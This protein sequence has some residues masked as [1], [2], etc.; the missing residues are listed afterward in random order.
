MNRSVALLTGVAGA[1]ALCIGACAAG[2]AGSKLTDDDDDSGQAAAGPGT[3]G[4]DFNPGDGGGDTGDGTICQTAPNLDLD[5]DDWTPSE[6]DCND[7]DANVNPGAIEVMT[8]LSDPNALEI[9]ENCDGEID[10][11]LPTCDDGLMLA[12]PDPLGAA[13]S[14][15]L[16]HD[17]TPGGKDFGVLYAHYVRA[18]G[19]PTAVNPS[20]GVLSAFGPNVSPRDGARMLGLSSGAARAVSDPDNCNGDYSC[21]HTGSGVAPPGFP[22]DMP[23]CG[24][25]G[26]INDD[27]GLEVRLRAPTNATGYSYD[28]TFYSFEYPEWVCTTFNDQYIALVDPAPPGSINGNISFD[29]LSNPVSVNIAFFDICTGCAGG[30]AEMQGTGFNDWDDAGATGWLQTTAPVEGGE[31]INI[32]F[33]IWDTGDSAWDSTVLI[34]N[35]KWIANGGTVDIG[36][37]PVPK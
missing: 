1:L 29:S 25:G 12:E 4:G 32:R 14:I 33:V 13:R 21:S 15:G 3:G 7:C 5:G 35:F 27:M 24:G 23:G 17:A 37:L 2:D 8:D 20:V 34:D 28:F 18:N 22:Q 11:A 30:V 9:D 26:D 36:T 19:Q 10:E 31:E 16:C 6:G